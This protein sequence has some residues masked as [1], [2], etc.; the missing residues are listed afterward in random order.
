MQGCDTNYKTLTHL[1][2]RYPQAIRKD[3]GLTMSSY[4]FGIPKCNIEK[5][6]GD[7]RQGFI[8][9]RD[10]IKASWMN[11]YINWFRSPRSYFEKESKKNICSIQKE[12]TVSDLFLNT[13]ST[14]ASK[15]RNE[16]KGEK[17]EKGRKPNHAVLL[18]QYL[19]VMFSFCI[20]CHAKPLLV[21]CR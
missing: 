6:K 10:L 19:Q 12:N 13:W 4:Q 3:L 5:E 16:E 20:F 2:E 7:A 8:L 15:P 1:N 18:K 11:V 9:K 17:K 14:N 21:S